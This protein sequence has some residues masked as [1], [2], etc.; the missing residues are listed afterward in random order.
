MMITTY[1]PSP[2]QKARPAGA[3][4]L[5]AP[6]LLLLAA[7]LTL[8]LLAAGCRDAG[9]S[10]QVYYRN[11][12]GQR[13]RIAVIPFLSPANAPDAGPVVTSTVI[14]YLLSTGAVDVVEP[15]TVDRAMRTARFVPTATGGMDPQM[16]A[17]L[18]QDLGV[19]AYLMGQ[20]E[21]YGDVRMGPDTYPSVSFSARLI[22]ASDN[23]IVWAASISKTGAD[24]VKVFDIGRI[25]S[26]GKL[27]KLAVEE[28][29]MSLRG[30]AADLLAAPGMSAPAP[31]P[32]PAQQA[33]QPRLRQVMLNPAF[34]DE[35]RAFGEAD[36]KALLPEVSGFTRGTV[37]YSKH[38]HDAV[39]ARYRTE[40]GIIEVK[41]IDYQ[42]A[43]TASKFVAQE[44]PGMQRE[45]I[46]T[47]PA[48]TSASAP[49][50]AGFVHFNAVVGRFGLY[51]SAPQDAADE[52]R[53]L[54]DA[55]IGSETS[56][57]KQ[58]K[59]DDLL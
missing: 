15:G 47:L 36:L 19:D 49:D 44:S 30:H 14:T 2:G 39:A 45:T 22:R 33:S 25:S 35:A 48:Y 54:T 7:G 23:T 50:H 59:A 42:K 10:S 16:T 56:G 40:D 11:A 51:I 38:F 57:N 20:V 58:A 32:A 52:A 31:A 4:R 6:A 3:R 1:R 21:E 8:A 17:A 55:I 41:L 37:E 12:S 53:K 13:L 26:V 9:P 29:A 5:P 46:G 28:M 43:D 27:T 34:S 18:Q 24:R